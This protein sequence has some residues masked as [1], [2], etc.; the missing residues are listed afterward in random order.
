MTS[1]NDWEKGLEM[2]VIRDEPVISS[3]ELAKMFGKRHDNVLRTINATV[4]LL[5]KNDGDERSRFGKANFI[6]SSFINS[7]NR[8]Y[9]EYLLTE[10]AFTLIV[11]R[12]KGTKA[13]AFKIAYI[14]KYNEMVQKITAISNRGMNYIEMAQS[15]MKKLNGDVS[16]D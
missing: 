8:C 16:D 3:R 13:F 5:M 1:L 15:I 2:A 12:F 10:D 9:P 7:R 4:Q 11:M 6:K 14:T